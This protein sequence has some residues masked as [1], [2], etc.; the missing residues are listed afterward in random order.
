MFKLLLLVNLGLASFSLLPFG[1]LDGV[2][3]ERFH[4]PWYVR[5]GLALNLV[6]IAVEA[7]FVL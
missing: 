1:P 7:G 3:A 2:E 5:I 4:K 6:G